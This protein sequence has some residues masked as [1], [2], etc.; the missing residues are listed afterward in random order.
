LPPDKAR[1]VVGRFRPT[2]LV[3]CGHHELGDIG[4]AA[5][6]ASLWGRLAA[7]EVPDWLEPVPETRGQPLVAYRV[8]L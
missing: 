7:G 3:T 6:S 8:K 5:R 2:Y 4:E 1:Y